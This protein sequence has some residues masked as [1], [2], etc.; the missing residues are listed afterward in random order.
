MLVKYKPVMFFG[1]CYICTMVDFQKICNK[2]PHKK[3]LYSMN[4][5]GL[6]WYFGKNKGI[7][8][9]FTVFDWFYVKKDSHMF[10]KIIMCSLTN[11]FKLRGV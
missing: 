11:I 3:K 1:D 2:V 9:L 7:S 8:L 5:P 10:D 4:V 6:L